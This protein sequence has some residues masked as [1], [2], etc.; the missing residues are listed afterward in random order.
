MNR[1]F[2]LAF[3]SI[4]LFM[5]N[6]LSA[7]TL[8]AKEF[9]EF[10]PLSLQKIAIKIHQ[11]IKKGD[12]VGYADDKLDREIA[13][14]AYNMIGLEEV[15]IAAQNPANPTDPMDL[16]ELTMLKYLSDGD[17]IPDMSF[18]FAIT[19]D[20]KGRQIRTV[21]ALAPSYRKT[22]NVGSKST[23]YHL[24]TGWVPLKA[25]KK[26]LSRE[27][28]ELINSYAWFKQMEPSQQLRREADTTSG[29][30][31]LVEYTLTENRLTLSGCEMAKNLGSSLHNRLCYALFEAYK[32]GAFVLQA[33]D[34]LVT[35]K[36][37]LKQFSHIE[38]VAMQ[39]P[40]SD[41]PEDLI[42]TLHTVEPIAFDELGFEKRGN[43]TIVIVTQ[44]EKL[45]VVY[46]AD[47]KYA[48]PFN[49]V[50]GLFHP[51]ELKLLNL[52]FGSKSQWEYK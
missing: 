42:D 21:Q 25:L 4:G 19:T 2:I 8:S 18:S 51:M 41:D 40:L 17:L 27:E 38:A 44:K 52:A 13:R 14:D 15:A 48:V 32:K 1:Y 45:N 24:P 29:L 12:L 6:T 28:M 3:A 20:R 35:A 26:I 9:K 16:I 23:F 47:F 10:V 7:Q 37:F 50:K 34:S 49:E 46:T 22:F 31:E 43:K 39:N 5:G 33:K 11:A 30:N 36:A